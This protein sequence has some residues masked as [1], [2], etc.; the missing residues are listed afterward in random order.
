M[1]LSV[2]AWRDVAPSPLSPFVARGDGDEAIAV[3]RI[4]C[5]RQKTASLM[6]HSILNLDRAGV[7]TRIPSG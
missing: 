2:V 3:R 4:A 1:R 5:S 6:Q 7:A